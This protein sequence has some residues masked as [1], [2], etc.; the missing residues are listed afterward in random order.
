MPRRI[1]DYT[2]AYA[3]WN[4]VSSIG[5]FISGAGTLIFVYLIYEA[6]VAKRQC[7]RQ[8]VGT[9]RDH[10]RMDRAVAGAVPHVRDPAAHFRR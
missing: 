3:T 5:A 9:R 4:F 10:A 6:F 1:V 8:S 7:P 2:D